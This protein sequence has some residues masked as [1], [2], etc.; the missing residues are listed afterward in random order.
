M[1]QDVTC[2]ERIRS[3]HIA[4]AGRVFC[5]FISGRLISLLFTT[6]KNNFFKWKLPSCIIQESRVYLKKKKFKKTCLIRK[7]QLIY[8]VYLLMLFLFRSR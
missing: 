1:K 7:R 8:N 2:L 4:Y 3:V 6:F 5:Y